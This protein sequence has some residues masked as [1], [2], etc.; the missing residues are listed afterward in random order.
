MA[1]ND[2][3]HSL[4]AQIGFDISNAEQSITRLKELFESVNKSISNIQQSTNK[5]NKNTVDKIND[6]INNMKIAQN[7]E[8]TDTGEIDNAIDTAIKKRIKGL[9]LSFKLPEGSNVQEVEIASTTINQWKKQMEAILKTVASDVKVVFPKSNAKDENGKKIQVEKLGNIKIPNETIEN[10]KAQIQHKLNMML[11][12]PKL[13]SLEFEDGDAMT[14]RFVVGKQHMD[15][16]IES[17]NTRI[18][19]LLGDPKNIIFPEAGA[20]DLRKPEIT[21][22]INR[23]R[24]ILTEKIS[25]FSVKDT[26]VDELSQIKLSTEGF[27]KN[28]DKFIADAKNV[29]KILNSINFKNVNLDVTASKDDLDKTAREFDKLKDRLSVLIHSYFNSLTEKVNEFS[30]KP[31]EATS[32][33]LVALVAEIDKSVGKYL[34]KLTSNF[35][36]ASGDVGD[37]SEITAKLAAL[38][39]SFYEME[40]SFTLY[41]SH[42]R[43]EVEKVSNAIKDLPKKF[44]NLATEVVKAS[45]GTDSRIT[46]VVDD[47]KAS[48]GSFDLVIKSKLEQVDD[49][50]D[51]IKALLLSTE[52]QKEEYAVQT[53]SSIINSIHVI[54]DIVTSALKVDTSEF[55]GQT[56]RIREALIKTAE[57][58]ENYLVNTFSTF[59]QKVDQAIAPVLKEKEQE[60][61]NKIREAIVEEVNRLVKS[62]DISSPSKVSF[63]ID[64]PAEMI[65]EKIRTTIINYLDDF[66]KGLIIESREQK[67][68]KVSFEDSDYAVLKGK[69][70]HAIT[71]LLDSFLNNTQIEYDK[72]NSA[73]NVSLNEV[74][75]KQKYI[76]SVVSLRAGYEKITEFLYSNTPE[77]IGFKLD[78]MKIRSKFKASLNALLNV[79]MES[80]DFNFFSGT[81]SK[82]SD[83]SSDKAIDPVVK[84]I[85]ES[86][87]DFKKKVNTK[88]I[89]DFKASLGSLEQVYNEFVD[90]L[91]KSI[92]DMVNLIVS[93]ESFQN[94]QLKIDLDYEKLKQNIKPDIIKAVNAIIDNLD[95]D[96]VNV[97]KM[98]L[99]VPEDELIKSIHQMVIDRINLMINEIKNKKMAGLPS[100]EKAAFTQTVKDLTTDLVQKMIT[101]SLTIVKEVKDEFEKTNVISLKPKEVEAVLKTL[102]V[103]LVDALMD[104]LKKTAHFMYQAVAKVSSTPVDF[105]QHYMSLDTEVRKQIAEAHNMTTKQF[106]KKNKFL[107]GDKGLQTIME[108]NMQIVMNRFNK[109]IGDQAT[110]IVEFYKDALTKVDIKPQGNTLST[111]ITRFTELQEAITKKAREIFDEQFKALMKEI[112][113]VSKNPLNYVFAYNSKSKVLR[114]PSQTIINNYNAPTTR[115]MSS[116]YSRPHPVNSNGFAPSAPINQFNNQLGDGTYWAGGSLWKNGEKVEDPGGHTRSFMGSVVNTIRYMT[117]GAIMGTPTMLGYKAFDAYQEA[118][119]QFTKAK[120]NLLAKDETN[121]ELRKWVNDEMKSAVQGIATAY[122]LP[123]A[124]A[125]RAFQVATQGYDNPYDALNLTR[126]TA[127]LRAVEEVDVEQSAKGL[128]AVASQYHLSGSQISDFSNMMI[129]AANL[130]LT[131]VED[132]LEIQKRTG[133]TFKQALPG[134]SSREQLATAV[135]MST[136]YTESTGK[137]GNMGGTFFKNLLASPFTQPARA[138]L[139]EMS[140]IKGLEKLNPYEKVF[141]KSGKP[142]MDAFGFQAKKQKNSLDLLLDI[143]DAFPKLDD[144]ARGQIFD[145]LSRWFRGDVAALIEDIKKVNS[146]KSLSKY[147]G[148][149]GFIDQLQGYKT[150][151]KGNRVKMSE[152]EA[153]KA[154]EDTTNRLAAMTMDAN[155]FKTQ[156][157]ETGFEIASSKIIDSFRNEMSV[158]LEKTAIILRL[159]GDN[160]S[161]ISQIVS[162]LAKL[163]IGFGIQAGVKYIGDKIKYKAQETLANKEKEKQEKVVDYI[164]KKRAVMQE[165]GRFINVRREMRAAKIA[166]DV[167]AFNKTMSMRDKSKAGLENINYQLENLRSNDKALNETRANL[168]AQNATTTQINDIDQ[169]I[170]KNQQKINDFERRKQL[171]Q[172][173]F[174]THDTA[175][176]TQRVNIRKAQNE[177]EIDN[178][179]AIGFNNRVDMFEQET[180]LLGI[181]KKSIK[182]PL[183]KVG[184]SANVYDLASQYMENQLKRLGNNTQVTKRELDGLNREF[185]QL[186]SEFGT[187]SISLEQF[188]TKLQR[189]ERQLRNIRTPV[190][191]GEGQSPVKLNTLGKVEDDKLQGVGFLELLGGLTVA[192]GLTSPEEA[193][194][195][196]IDPNAPIS[197]RQRLMRGARQ[198]ATLGFQGI[199]TAGLGVGASLGFSSASNAYISGAAT[200]AENKSMKADET[201]ALINRVYAARK[202]K[203]EGKWFQGFM[204]D[205]GAGFAIAYNNIS[206]LFGATNTLNNS[207][208]SDLNAL[209]NAAGSA[210][211][212]K[213]LANISFDPE[214]N[215]IEAR[216]AMIKEQEELDKKM[217]WLDSNKDGKGDM[218]GKTDYKDLVTFEEGQQANA[219]IIQQMQNKL[220]VSGSKASI[221]R[222]DLLLKGYSETSTEITD[223]LTKSIDENVKILE[224]AIAEMRKNLG[225]YDP[226]S[227]AYQGALA[228]LTQT[229]AQLAEEKRKKQLN[230]LQSP[231]DTKMIE[232]DR[233]NTSLSA[234]ANID[235]FNL[236]QKGY[237]T[238]SVQWL[239]RDREYKQKLLAIEANRLSYLQNQLAKPEY[240]NNTDMANSLLEKI[241]STSQN[242]TT[243]LQDIRENT[244]PDKATFNMPSDVKALSYF[245]YVSRNGTNK[246][247][248]VAQGGITVNMN[249]ATVNANSPTD[250]QALGQA[251]ISGLKQSVSNVNSN[252]ASNVNNKYTINK[253]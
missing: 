253:R 160:A 157:V 54:R 59:G 3:I 196:N 151:E 48:L 38:Q 101:S 57:A 214:T 64:L 60:L 84:A 113:A 9:K 121:T 73:V 198:A 173:T 110:K 179:R 229:E 50:L 165:E 222:V 200:E 212:F 53:A 83:T 155:K 96:P 27:Y 123:Q 158:M 122:A 207:E 152:E 166:D 144:S 36:K 143:T 79:Y 100:K 228:Q 172:T 145:L 227:A 190:Q 115:S 245:E 234:K 142:V 217:P 29:G 130:K 192:N 75:L 42:A 148:V 19:E 81:L 201:K 94:T 80:V 109:V 185:E 105:K 248:S 12:N 41:L 24:T 226:K 17:I 154:L 86:M 225:R 69:L 202:A 204:L 246:N 197:R 159:L 116:P 215:S 182:A 206:S 135:A 139:E 129:L 71:D 67:Q 186:Q 230:M 176:K 247:V 237:N 85:Q 76:D 211:Q 92:K 25:E 194:N 169:E 195:V 91:V 208:L 167:Q 137:S 177:N 97:Q 106:E 6:F 77:S 252:V 138:K 7:V 111:L 118:D 146:N 168:V 74:L 199:T 124:E 193:P 28:L 66:I 189:L 22:L 250:L 114:T 249:I 21:N 153:A 58:I 8:I 131:K 31:D 133:A 14:K 112:N 128:Q 20:I 34:D 171:A 35:K 61:T 32:K 23:I 68:S 235:F 132:L 87:D 236:Y 216:V 238:S 231:L 18:F 141:D 10:I 125:A 136:L 240:A 49:V 119:Y 164:N 55:S 156:R 239:S 244:N 205:A 43:T 184:D 140:T 120:V 241:A 45:N 181:D 243:L 40:S 5:L 219:Y 46:K 30:K 62:F 220:Q 161:G 93:H 126:S 150:D 39:L 107:N 175:Y 33:A 37:G 70:N 180:E 15:K 82:G 178:L 251:V 26:A 149:R 242:M 47:I 232:F 183:S 13:S 4:S 88:I 221:S 16:L 134:M 223:L 52:F 89:T 1:E 203:E 224:E 11:T 95:F 72:K 108:A 98:M 210:Q 63:S 163:A 78:E 174:D 170:S 218:V 187:G 51:K 213:D 56:Q 103:Q 209:S 117:A 188:I 2:N 44:S 104:R 191:V 162:L 233:S 127:K 147:G 90:D 102:D 65:N 99:K